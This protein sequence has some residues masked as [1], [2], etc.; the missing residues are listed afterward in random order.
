[1]QSL[2]NKNQSSLDAD[3]VKFFMD[4]EDNTDAQDLIIDVVKQDLEHLKSNHK[5]FKSK[6]KDIKEKK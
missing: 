6:I 2:E 3:I 5:S 1:M 4:F